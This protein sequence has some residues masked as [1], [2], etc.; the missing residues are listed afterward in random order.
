MNIFL[1]EV[2]QPPLEGVP[3]SYLLKVYFKDIQDLVLKFPRE[4]TFENVMKMS[5]EMHQVAE[6]GVQFLKNFL[7]LHPPPPHTIPS[8][9]GTQIYSL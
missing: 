1:V 3:L 5:S 7:G 8:K 9:I 6:I 4:K 2:S